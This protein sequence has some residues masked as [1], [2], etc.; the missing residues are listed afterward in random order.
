V[1]NS[2]S[3]FLRAIPPAISFLFFPHA[4]KRLMRFGVGTLMSLLL[5]FPDPGYCFDFGSLVDDVGDAISSGIDSLE[6][7]IDQMTEDSPESSGKGTTGSKNQEGSEKN[8]SSS[9]IQKE[10]AKTTPANKQKPGVSKSKGMTAGSGNVGDSVFSKNPIDPESPPSSTSSF[11]AGDKIYGMLRAAKPWK[12]LN[13]NNNYIIVWLYI[14]G[15]KKAYKSIG[16]RRPELLALDYFIIDV[17]PDPSSMTNYTDRDIVFPEKD[18]YKFG[19]ELF[20]KYLSELAPG[21]HSFRLEVKA[22]NKV[23]AAGE[24]S[25]SG[26]DYGV[27][28]S[29][30]ADIKESSG[31]QQ[32]MPK[33]GITN[34]NLQN[35]MAALLKNAG[36]PD[37]RRLIIVDKDWWLDRVAGGDSPIKSRHIEAAV[38]AKG[39]NGDFYFRHATF[40]QPMLITGDWGKLQLTHTGKKKPIL[41]KNIDS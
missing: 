38:A 2:S 32:K 10:S 33:P 13:R 19:P 31:K 6:K 35:D 30:L 23:Y 41:E 17:A 15:Q 11:A 34:Q 14:D 36:W 22:Y 25:I 39:S 9:A 8:S 1:K 40:H 27:Y 12:E 37:I 21:E 29:L 26:D 18:G 4:P 28:T 3:T 5:L 20:T 16:L 7:S 24:F